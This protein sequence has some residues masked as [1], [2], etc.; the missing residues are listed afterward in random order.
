MEKLNFVSTLTN[1]TLTLT[2]GGKVDSDNAAELTDYCVTA[3]EAAHKNLVFDLESLE[4]ISSA[5]LRV[6]LAMLKKEPNP[7]KAINVSQEVYEVL[8]VTGFAQM[9]EASR[10]RRIVSIDGCVKIGQGGQGAVYRLDKDT[11]IKVFRPEMPLAEIE[12]ERSYAQQAFMLGLPTAI[13]YDVV[14]CGDS[15]GLVFEMLN[16]DTVA[17]LINKEPEKLEYYAKEYAKM[18]KKAHTVDVTG[19]GFPSAKEKCREGFKRALQKGNISQEQADGCIRIVESLPERASFVHSDLNANN[20][21]LQN[22][23]MLLIDM[24]TAGFGHPIIDVASIYMTSG[25]PGKAG[26]R[27]DEHVDGLSNAMSPEQ[28]LRVW[29]IF[30]QEYFE[31]LDKETLNAL[32]YDCETFMFLSLALIGCGG[33]EMGLAEGIV[34]MTRATCEAIFFPE[35]EERYE[36]LNYTLWGDAQ[37]RANKPKPER[38]GLLDKLLNRNKKTE[39]TE[40]TLDTKIKYI[41]AN[42]NAAAILERV[43]P[44]FTESP[45]LKLAYGMTLRAI[46]KFPQANISMEQLEEIGREFAKL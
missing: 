4:Y 10:A 13:S 2:I 12:K 39:I 30:M 6:L 9:L 41:V 21:M 28:S 40:I 37:A 46:Q 44:G 25:F 22:G 34:T 33:I 38:R 26:A 31:T 16:A 24:G 17:A 45:Q 11:I 1:D 18:A 19:T 3:C 7:V 35:L 42:Q 14:K 36:K 23:E 20:V 8:E 27:I 5:G 15:L 32:E 43:L 29:E